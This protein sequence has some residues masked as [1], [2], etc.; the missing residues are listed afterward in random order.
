MLEDFMNGGAEQLPYHL[1]SILFKI[2][3]MLM[4]KTHNL[5][6]V[7]KFSHRDMRVTLGIGRPL[8]DVDK[9]LR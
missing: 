4:L 6:R 3:P 2:I 1:R 8:D 9:R 7:K 5:R